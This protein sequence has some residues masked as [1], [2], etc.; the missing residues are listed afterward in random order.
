[1]GE[2]STISYEHSNN[3]IYGSTIQIQQLKICVCKNVCRTASQSQG[4]IQGMYSLPPLGEL[5]DGSPEERR[6]SQSQYPSWRRF[7]RC[8]QIEFGPI[9]NYQDVCAYSII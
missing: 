1:V 8:P 4:G 5:A 6:S 9:R 7:T 3:N 2:K